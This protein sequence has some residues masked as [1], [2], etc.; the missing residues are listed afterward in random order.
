MGCLDREE[1]I[2]QCL[3]RATYVLKRGVKS[4][5]LAL[6]TGITK[7]ELNRGLNSLIEK[8]IVVRE[9][10]HTHT[11]YSL[12]KRGGE[13]KPV[14]RP[15]KDPSELKTKDHVRISKKDRSFIEGKG[16]SLQSFLDY[17]IALE[18]GGAVSSSE[19]QKKAFVKKA[20]GKEDL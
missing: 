14:G 2:I 3:K 7:T 5:Y 10:R 11:T 13:V 16:F 18:K 9:G 12:V 17:S 4:S 8:G 19:Y 6:E 1:K 15:K 20:F